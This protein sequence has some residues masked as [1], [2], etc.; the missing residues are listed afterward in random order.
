LSEL[1]I[2]NSFICTCFLVIKKNSYV[3]NCNGDIKWIYDNPKRKKSWV[4][5][6]I[7]ID[8]KTHPWK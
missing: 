8:F 5:P 7:D 4:R 3:S 2:Q 6:T 1:A